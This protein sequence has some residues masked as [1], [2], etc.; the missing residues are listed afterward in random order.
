M[1]GIHHV[2]IWVADLDA[3]VDGWSWLFTSPCG[4][5]P[6]PTSTP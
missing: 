2:E 5:A 1:K 3:V 4:A 6:R